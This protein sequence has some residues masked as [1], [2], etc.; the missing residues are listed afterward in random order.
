M[1][2]DSPVRR[3]ALLDADERGPGSDGRARDDGPR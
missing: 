1:H 3:Q 2:H